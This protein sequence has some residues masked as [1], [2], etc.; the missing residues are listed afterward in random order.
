MIALIDTKRQH[1]HESSKCQINPT[2]SIYDLHSFQWLDNLKS[3]FNLQISTTKKGME[4]KAMLTGRDPRAAS[5]QP[6]AATA[7]LCRG[8]G[9]AT[10]SIGDRE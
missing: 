8:A 4:E 2:I 6:L 5:G 7:R 3:T 1:F 10:G 9:G